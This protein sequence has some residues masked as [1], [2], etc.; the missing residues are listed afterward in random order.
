M[1]RASPDRRRRQSSVKPLLES[2]LGSVLPEQ[3]GGQMAVLQ[4]TAKSLQI[5]ESGYRM[6]E[7]PHHSWQGREF[8]TP[9][10]RS[11]AAAT[12]DS[13]HDRPALSLPCPC[14][15]RFRSRRAVERRGWRPAGLFPMASAQDRA[16]PQAPSLCT[17]GTSGHG[18]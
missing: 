15:G 12:H 9:L 2:G 8:A 11:R 10:P 5:S 3:K 4:P 17:S 7:I 1:S 14:A 18:C 6:D 16:S 13:M